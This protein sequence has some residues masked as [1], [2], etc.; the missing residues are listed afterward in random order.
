MLLQ[1]VVLSVRFTLTRNAGKICIDKIHSNYYIL[2]YSRDPAQCRTV[3]DGA[4]I[5][6]IEQYT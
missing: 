6:M 1:P 2:E 4:M 5:C 3:R